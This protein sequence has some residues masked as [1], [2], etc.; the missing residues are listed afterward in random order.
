MSKPSPAKKPAS[1]S[2]L[3]GPQRKTERLSEVSRLTKNAKQF[4]RRDY[5]GQ[6]QIESVLKI[7]D[8]KIA[9]EGI[10]L[11]KDAKIAVAKLLID[12]GKK[13]IE[14]CRKRTTPP[15][16]EIIRLCGG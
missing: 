12:Q 10:F 4:V 14:S 2:Q 7:I 6:D 9:S 13:Q 3:P 8:D 16:D 11:S 5:G 15:L 1:I